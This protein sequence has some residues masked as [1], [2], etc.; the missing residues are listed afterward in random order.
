MLQDKQLN[1]R[2]ARFVEEYLVD[3]NAT[4]AAIRAGYSPD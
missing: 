2:Q 4:Q 3:L 1:P